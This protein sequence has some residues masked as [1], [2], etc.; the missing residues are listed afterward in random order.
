[1]ETVDPANKNSINFLSI[2]DIRVNGNYLYVV[3]EKLSSVGRYDIEYIRTH[4][5]V[6]GWNVKNIRLIDML[7]G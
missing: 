5:G 1:M 3:D 6:M 4:Q 7:Q 2:K